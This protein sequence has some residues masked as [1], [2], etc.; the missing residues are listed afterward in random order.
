MINNA[1]DWRN[2]TK[3]K[4]RNIGTVRHGTEIASLVAPRIWSSIPKEYEECNSVNKIKASK[5]KL[6]LGFRIQKTYHATFAKILY[7]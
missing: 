5:Q 1:Y 6:R 3:Y 2:E 4:S 7:L